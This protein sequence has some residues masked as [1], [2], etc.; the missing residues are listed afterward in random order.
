MICINPN[1]PKPQNSNANIFCTA[2]GSELLLQGRYQVVRLI[3]TV[4]FERTYDVDDA[5][6]TK[7]LKV[8]N[9]GVNNAYYINIIVSLLKREQSVLQQLNY[10]GIPKVDKNAY[11]IYFPRNTQEPLHCLITEK[12]VGV[13][14]NEWLQQAGRLTDEKLA[15]EWLI[16][17]VNI[18]DELHQ[19]KFVHRDIKPSNIILQPNGSLGLIDF[20]VVQEITPSYL[21]DIEKNEPTEAIG[22]F[23]YTPPEQF[24]GYSVFQSDF[25]ALGRTFVELLTGTYI[26]ELE[27]DNSN[28]IE[29]RPFATNISPMLADL[30]DYLMMPSPNE[31]P[32]D[33]K[34]ILQRLSDIQLNRL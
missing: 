21:A 13:T 7:V 11:F 2:C 23:G 14:L 31:R 27:V 24:Q 6:V 4:G 16:N 3:E 29:W 28:N 12:I 34:E 15:I 30:L 33:A 22:T 25:F 9:P 26:R 10:P 17:L 18:L 19:K 32:T 8:L 5:G 20:S 1:C